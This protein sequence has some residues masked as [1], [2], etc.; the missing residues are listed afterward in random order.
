M[1]QGGRISVLKVMKLL[2]LADREFLNRDDALI[3]D[4]NY[5]SMDHGPVSS[6]TFNYINGGYPDLRSWNEFVRDREDNEISAS[7]DQLTEDSLDELSRAELRV[8]EHIWEQHG[9]KT[10]W[11]LRNWT[12]RNCPEW[13]DPEGS[14]RPITYQSIF[15]ALGKENAQQLAERL[16]EEMNRA[17]ADA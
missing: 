6:R 16:Q 11:Q 4:D 2:Y 13:I 3:L 9:N 14:S 17:I 10:P 8:L 1:K 7:S 5:V 15:E 12:H